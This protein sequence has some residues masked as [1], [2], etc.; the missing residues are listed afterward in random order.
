MCGIYGGVSLAGQPLEHPEVL[1][2]MAN[3]LRHRGPDGHGLL[4]SPGAALGACRLR[5]QDP[6]SAGDQPFT[7]E[8]RQLWLACN[9]EIYNA[10]TLRA[11][12]ATYPYRSRA[13]TE[14]L[15][16]LFRERGTDAVGDV[17]GMFALAVWD[18]HKRTIHLARD[19]AGE[20]PLFYTR[21]KN[22]VW[23]ASEI[24]ALLEHPGVHRTIDPVAVDDLLVMGYVLEPRTLF[25]AIRKVPAGTVLSISRSTVTLT[26]Y[27]DPEHISPEPVTTAH[28]VARVD[29]LLQDAVA[30]QLVSDAPLGVFGSGGVDS[31]LLAAMAVRAIGAERLRVFTAA[32]DDRSYDESAPA[33]AVASHLGIRHTVIPV[34]PPDALHALD[35]LTTSIAEP[36]ADPAVLPTYLL[37]ARAAEEVKVVMSGEGADELFGGY[38]TYL[39]HRLAPVFGGLPSFVKRATLATVSLLPVSPDKVPLTFLVKRFLTAA[40]RPWLERHVRWFGT[41]LPDTL[42][43]RRWLGEHRGP[44]M[45]HAVANGL[46]AVMLLDYR[47]YLRDGLLTK[48]DR[49]T[50]LASIEARAPYLDRNLSA[51][52]LGLPPELKLRGITTKWIL[53]EVASRWLPGWCVSRAKRGLSVPMARWLNHDLR[54]EVERLLAP[55]RTA[56]RGVLQP[57]LVHQ[58]VSEHRSGRANH[59]RA[60]WPILVLERW[61]ERWVEGG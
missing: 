40:E 45:H 20:K 5:I 58:L 35:Q 17:D 30:R 39:G 55:E 25:S 50:M 28:A 13:D 1:D 38:P 19:R 47:T 29:A 26:K 60:L 18:G 46:T 14:P 43:V 42:R 3:R 44:E 56:A 24:Q 59:A 4:R 57:G 54:S 15:L 51:F 36:L 37:A 53:K 9:G 49:A 6:R 2:R 21:L 33:A 48:L 8:S 23:F 10:P 12:Y 32:F 27:W 41:G 22:E 11:R 61:Y 16:P 34:R 7:D 52:V 31:S